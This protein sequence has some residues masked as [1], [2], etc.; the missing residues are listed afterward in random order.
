MCWRCDSH[1]EPSWHLTCASLDRDKYRCNATPI[2]AASHLRSEPCHTCLHAVMSSTHASLH[3]PG[4]AFCLLNPQNERAWMQKH[5]LG[6]AVL[7]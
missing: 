2:S 4:H 3:G 1:P 6:I 7:C 5:L